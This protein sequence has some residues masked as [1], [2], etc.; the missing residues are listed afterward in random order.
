MIESLSDIL[1]VSD[2]DGTL[3]YEKQGISTENINAIKRFTEKGGH[4]TVATG[5]AI[6]ITKKLVKDVEI[7]T[8]SIHINGGYLYDWENDKII[9]PHYISSSAKFYCKKIVEKYPFC[10]CHFADSYAVNVVTSGKTLEKYI[11]K[12]EAK[13]FELGF[14]NVPENA[15][16]FIISCDP[17]YMKDVRDYAEEISGK[18]VKIIQSSAFFLEILPKDN[19]KVNSLKQLCKMLDLPLENVVAVGDY[20]NDIEMLK[21]AGIGAAVDNAQDIVKKEADIILPPCEDNAISHLI[22]FLEEMY[23]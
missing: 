3:L 2:I 18:D 10:D 23:G 1:I 4:F 12:G 22:S 14:E 11:V 21:V 15:Y 6:D 16:K 7:N 17:E 19:S 13:Y 20:E 5:R 9:D 8:P